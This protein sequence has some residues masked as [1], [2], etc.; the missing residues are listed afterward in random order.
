MSTEFLIL[1]YWSVGVT[2]LALLRLRIGIF[3][4]SVHQA[5]A[6]RAFANIAQYGQPRSQ[7]FLPTMIFGQEGLETSGVIFLISGM[8]TTL[9]VALPA[10]IRH[11]PPHTQLTIPPVPTWGLW[12][13]G[14][15]LA[16]F[17]VSV[18]T[19]FTGSYATQGQILFDAPSGGV[20]A[21]VVGTIIYELYRRVQARKLTPL[22]AF[23]AFL[24]ICF[25]TDYSKGSTGFAT[26][27]LMTGIFLFCSTQ[28]GIVKRWVP[29]IGALSLIILMA[30]LIRTARHTLHQDGIDA[31][32]SAGSTLT[33]AESSRSEN[34]EG[35]EERSNGSQIA[36]HVLECVWLYDNGY[37]RQWRSFYNPI[38]YTFQPA[39]L[40]KILNIEREEEAAWELGRYFVHGGG[41]FIFGEMYWNGGYLCVFLM[42]ASLL[43]LAW[44]VDTRRDVSFNALLFAC[45]F[46][47]SLFQ[48]TQ[49]GVTYPARGF[50]NAVLAIL[51]FRLARWAS[52][53]RVTHRVSK[54][55]LS[56]EAR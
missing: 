26:G 19:I 8:L 11:R 39:F 14:I 37:D 21:I 5:T 12:A 31:L 24:I 32:T 22:R 3:F 18:K 4:I 43:A 42:T 28:T 27:F 45:M 17:T 52:A 46:T 6:L 33:S 13:I 35:I 30:L 36:A 48:G 49:Y 40:M 9:F 56:R 29:L 50:S 20:Q 10:S 7:A 44:F 55:V 47:P 51:I 41:L 2:L 16:I 1:F 25:V 23:I 53:S 34:A 38:L 15:Y 54:R